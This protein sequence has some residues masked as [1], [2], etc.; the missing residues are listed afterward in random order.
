M[1]DRAVTL[2]EA[3]R[4]LDVTPAAVR[5]WIRQGAP[6][7]SMGSRGRGNGA[8]V[9]VGELV[10]WRA[11]RA[12]LPPVPGDPAIALPIIASARAD[13]FRRDAGGPTALP[14]HRELGIDDRRAAAFLALIYDRLHLALR[15]ESATTLPPEIETLVTN[16]LASRRTRPGG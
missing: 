6:C 14:A 4:E 15:G 13:V 16:S 3:A 9:Y 12:G 10:R 11:Q 1:T 7:A 5:N 8:R 2:A